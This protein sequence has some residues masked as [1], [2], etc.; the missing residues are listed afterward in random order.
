M[1]VEL[2]EVQMLR[3]K[4]SAFTLVELL[5]VIAI[6]A[7]LISILLPAINRARL[8]GRL[9]ACQA[10]L[11]QI[12]QWGQ[13]YVNAYKGVLPTHG[14]GSDANTW[15]NPPDPS[16]NGNNTWHAKAGDPWNNLFKAGSR[17]GT[18]F[19]CPEGIQVPLRPS[20]R[21]IN[22]GLNHY[23]GGRRDFGGAGIA[24]KPTAKMLKSRTYWFADARVFASSG[25]FDF[26]PVLTL[27]GTSTAVSVNWPWVW[28]SSSVA[29]GT[30][31]QGHPN[32]TA[33]FLFGDGHVE[34]VTQ[35]QFQS[36]SGSTLRIFTGY[37]F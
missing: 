31:F 18:V 35:K 22:Y 1:F 11:R 2:L 6:I 7:V 8:H 32:H 34:G 27:S 23:L 3:R 19:H 24:P 28:N 17:S 13:M 21:G 16:W 29:N 14:D 12:G 25:A 5:V 37:P 20:V 9:V 30:N 26:H 10:N 33:N 36:M 4:Q 15:A